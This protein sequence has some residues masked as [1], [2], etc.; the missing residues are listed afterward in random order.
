MAEIVNF[1]IINSYHNRNDRYVLAKKDGNFYINNNLITTKTRDQFTAAEEEHLLECYDNVDEYNVFTM[2]VC[3]ALWGQDDLSDTFD[4]IHQD[5]IAYL[6]YTL[7]NNS[8]TLVNGST[9]IFE[10]GKL[11]YGAKSIDLP[12]VGSDYAE[13]SVWDELPELFN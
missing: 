8:N 13:W 6:L 3:F 5:I 7:N 9:I 2:A 11:S 10:P 1:V 12:T 4:P